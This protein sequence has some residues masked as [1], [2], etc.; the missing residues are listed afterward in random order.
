M[1]VGLVD[2]DQVYPQ[3]AVKE[4]SNTRFIHQRIQWCKR[5]NYSEGLHVI[6]TKKETE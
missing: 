6:K 5:T 1:V 3:D 4:A 2:R